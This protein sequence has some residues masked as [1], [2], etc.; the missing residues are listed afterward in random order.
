MKTL[1]EDEIRQWLV[2]HIPHRMRILFASTGELDNLRPKGRPSWPD[3][4]VKRCWT[5]AVWDG[6][7]VAM[8]WSCEFVGI[9]MDKSGNP[10]KHDVSQSKDPRREHDINITALPAGQLIDVHSDDATVIAKAWKATTQISLHPT[11]DSNP[12]PIDDNARSNAFRIIRE[13]LTNTIY[14]D[15]PDWIE[16]WVLQPPPTA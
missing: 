5:D 2:L 10:Q 7:L 12:P 8:R 1:N 9:T 11:H 13:H 14:K 16:Q 4:I 15:C 6:R 3:L